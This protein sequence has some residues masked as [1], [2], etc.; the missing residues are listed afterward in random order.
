[1]VFQQSQITFKEKG[2]LVSFESGS[3]WRYYPY[4]Q[5]NHISTHIKDIS[6]PKWHE[7][8]VVFHMNTPTGLSTIIIRCKDG[9]D[10][11][12]FFQQCMERIDSH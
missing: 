1:M 7:F 3:P 10:T 11:N 9:P 5:V 12:S 8:W 2:F 4:T 6:D